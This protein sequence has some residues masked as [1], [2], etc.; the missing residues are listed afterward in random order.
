MVAGRRVGRVAPFL[1][2]ACDRTLAGP[3]VNLNPLQ[4]SS[5]ATLKL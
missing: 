5:T 3:G 2:I 1:P 4:K